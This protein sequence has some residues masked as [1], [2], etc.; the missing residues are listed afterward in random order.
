MF[1]LVHSVLINNNYAQLIGL[2]CVK[3]CLISLSISSK[4]Q[5]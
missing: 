3:I 5:F 4:K 1:G 2:I